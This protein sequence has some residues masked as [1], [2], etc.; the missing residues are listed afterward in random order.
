[1]AF[2]EGRGLGWGD[3]RSLGFGCWRDNLERV[4]SRVNH[5]DQPFLQVPGQVVFRVF[6]GT[7]SFHILVWSLPGDS[8]CVSFSVTVVTNIE[9][10]EAYTV[11]YEHPW[12]WCSIFTSSCHQ[13]SNWNTASFSLWNLKNSELDFISHWSFFPCIITALSPRRFPVPLPG[14]VS[15]LLGLPMRLAPLVFG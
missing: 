11:C 14:W 12:R 6:S 5:P 3:P 9:E 4:W 8:S 15:A 2:I 1:M 13:Y 10:N 7:W